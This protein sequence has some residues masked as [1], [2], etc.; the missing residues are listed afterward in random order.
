MHTLTTHKLRD[1]SQC[2]V[3]PRQF[4]ELGSLC[5]SVASANARETA[6]LAI[7]E[8]GQASRSLRL[9]L[10]FYGYFSIGLIGVLVV[11]ISRL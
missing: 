8:L 9:S 3:E 11:L 4:G 7:A 10:K 5:Y 1:C 2:G 6:E